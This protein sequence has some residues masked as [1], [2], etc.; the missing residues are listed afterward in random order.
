MYVC[1]STVYSRTIHIS[2]RVYLVFVGVLEKRRPRL[3]INP[4]GR[5]SCRLRAQLVSRL[6]YRVGGV[7]DAV[8]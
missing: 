2:V 6:R 4:T 5:G 8:P 1:I 7:S 3:R